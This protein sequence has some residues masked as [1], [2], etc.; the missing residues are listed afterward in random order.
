[1][2]LWYSHAN[3]SRAVSVTTHTGFGLLVLFGSIVIGSLVFIFL[4]FK[5]YHM[6][7]QPPGGVP[8]K[9][10]SENMQEKFTGEYPCRS[11]ISIKLLC[12]FIE[13]TL[14]HRCSPVNLQ[15]IFRTRFTKNTSG[16]LLL[17]MVVPSTVHS[18][19]SVFGASLPIKGPV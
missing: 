18:L 11:V 7:K 5:M 12:K 15:H 1:M 2:Y 13:T 10:C 17:D 16:W 8:R 4:P 9:R 14:R 3:G 19:L 6:Q